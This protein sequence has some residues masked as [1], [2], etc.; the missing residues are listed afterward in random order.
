MTIIIITAFDFAPFT[1]DAFATYL[2]FYGYKIIQTTTVIIVAKDSSLVDPFGFKITGVCDQYVQTTTLTEFEVSIT[3]ACGYTDLSVVI[4][5]NRDK[6]QPE[7][8]KSYDKK[9]K[10]EFC[11]KEGIYEWK[12]IPNVPLIYKDKTLK[13]N[14]KGGHLLVFQL[15]SRGIA[16]AGAVFYSRVFSLKT[17]ISQIKGRTIDDS[18]RGKSRLPIA[19]LNE[20]IHIAHKRTANALLEDNQRILQPERSHK[21]RS[22]EIIIP[23]STSVLSPQQDPVVESESPI[24]HPPP[25]KKRKIPTSLAQSQ[26]EMIDAVSVPSSP[27]TDRMQT[28]NNS[29][30]TTRKQIVASS[31]SDIRASSGQSL[32]I[33]FS[34][35]NTVSSPDYIY[36]T[37]YISPA[38]FRLSGI[39]GH[40]QE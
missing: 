38:P 36:P 33:S 18:R 2:V 7:L 22:R 30:H 4:S 16:I 29:S 19:L 25:Q 13:I 20:A 28:L 11:Q 39:Y 5:A 9:L 40:S 31:N 32:N 26:P 12:I 15:A 10:S 35:L 17:S 8:S 3:S 21:T 34:F 6:G 14:C 24:F 23:E 27:F 37:P 1:W